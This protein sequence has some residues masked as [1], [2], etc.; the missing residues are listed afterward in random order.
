MQSSRFSIR[1]V[2]IAGLIAGLV[3]LTSVVGCRRSGAPAPGVWAEV[4]GR[5]ILREQVERILH[6]HGPASQAADPQETL[7]FEL[8]I[9]DELINRQVLLDHAVRSGITVSEAEVDTQVARL[10]SPYSKD[11][12]EKQLEAQGMDM[13]MLRQEIRSNLLVEKLLNRDVSSHVNIKQAEM[14]AYYDRNKASF[15]VPETSYHLAQILVTPYPMHGLNNLKNDDAKTPLTA[16]RKIQA[17]YARLRSGAD[18]STVAE[19]YS[20]DAR[21]A[22][23]GGDLGYVPESALKKNPELFKIV[24]SLPVGGMSGIIRTSS[25]FHIVKLLGVE[26]AGQLPF[27]D[28]SVQQT[29]R[30]TLG[31]EK[32]Q[33]LKAA[34]IEV[35]RD[36]DKVRNYLAERIL[37]D[38][39][40]PL[41]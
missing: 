32:E 9:L 11:T 38:A 41:P 23:N 25:G 1:L 5:P 20:E 14:Q 17:L 12:F 7:S 35:L 10:E 6:S 16:E 26:K 29:I 37:K 8:N 33:L 39:G 30:R 40:E 2:K 31:D 4:N 24:T 3:A 21:S 22:P 28:A 27:S 15:N 34:Y 19:N 13:S 36:S 18:F